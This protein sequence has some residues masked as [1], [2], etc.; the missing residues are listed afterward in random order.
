M[1]ENM[2]MMDPLDDI[3]INN[4]DDVDDDFQTPQK[5][6]DTHLNVNTDGLADRLL[7]VRGEDLLLENKINWLKQLATYN[8]LEVDINNIRLVAPFVSKR[9]NKY[10]FKDE[11]GD[12]I[13]INNDRDKLVFKPLKFS[14]MK[15]SASDNLLFQLGY[16]KRKNKLVK[17]AAEGNDNISPIRKKL[18]DTIQNNV[19]SP[20]HDWEDIQMVGVGPLEKREIEGLEQAFTNI[21]DNIKLAS[22]KIMRHNDVIS[23]LEKTIAD[24]EAKPSIEDH[25]AELATAKRLL[26]EEK[27][28]LQLNMD[29]RDELKGQMKN[30]LTRL[31]DLYKL[32]LGERLRTLFREEGV[33][34]IS[35]VTAVG[36]TISTIVLAVGSLFTPAAAV[37]APGGPSGNY[38][39]KKNIARVGLEKVA[40]ILKNLASA[41]VK[42]LPAII[43]SIVS[44]IL[45][46]MGKV[47]SWAA[48]HLYIV[49]VGVV[50][51]ILSYFKFI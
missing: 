20:P 22:G 10:F 37:V 2:E 39:P 44:F 29:L 33:T 5:Q 1:A 47:V 7:Q 19:A 12:E 3:I 36:M 14:S 16:I 27:D 4:D 18:I 23:K 8:G 46:T 6:Y 26:R 9:V 21:R 31:K 25:E 45:S 34:V 43:G 30:Q 42:A 32:P 40:Q 38:I 11:N 13:V 28:K 35:I 50:G 15:G 48:E 41:A 24:L 51:L 17:M 49:L